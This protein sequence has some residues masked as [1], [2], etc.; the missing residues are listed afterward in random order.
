MANPQTIRRIQLI[1][2]WAFIAAA[3]ALLFSRH[4]ALAMLTLIVGVGLSR[5]TKSQ[6]GFEPGGSVDMSAV[7]SPKPVRWFIGVMLLV[8]VAGAYWL[9]QYAEHHESLGTAPVYIFA[10]AVGAAAWWSFGL[11]TRWL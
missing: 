6:S 2:A 5:R 3:G 9:L 1:L 8:L 11:L 4:N 10:A 7:D